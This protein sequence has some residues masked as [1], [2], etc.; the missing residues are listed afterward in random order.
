MGQTKRN[1]TSRLKEHHPGNKPE[2]RAY[3]TK[4]L[5]KN[6]SHVVNFNEPEI[7]TKVNHPRELFLKNSTYL[8]AT[9]L[10]QC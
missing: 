5:P 1:L 4:H 3:V 2:T 10:N 7:L 8:I 6:P 9:T